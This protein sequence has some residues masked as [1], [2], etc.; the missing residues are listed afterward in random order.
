MIELKSICDYLEQFA[1]PQLA[2]DWDNVGLLVGDPQL[3]VQRI[4]TCL[5]VTPASAEEAVREGANLIVTHHPLP[6]RPLKRLTTDSTPGRLVLQLVRAGVAVYSP[7]TA[8]D[9]AAA[10]INQQ[11][12]AG[13]GLVETVPLVAKTDQ[14]PVLGAGRCGT[15]PQPATLAELAERLKAFLHIDGLHVVG[16]AEQ[17]LSRVAVA[18]G[19]A[20]EFLEQ[21][22]QADCDAL[23]VGETTFHTCLEAEAQGVA[24]L[25]PGHFASERF[26]VVKL[27]EHLAAQFRELHVWA[28]R[29][30]CDPLRW[31]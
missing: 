3:H 10:G 22:R 30:E 21:A 16:P 26:A 29:Q 2:E 8:F 19:A 15:L 31:V 18:C 1:P 23:V 4:M 28:S 27:A 13:L 14:V 6:F 12:A 7:H 24:L 9:S 20:G 5:T 11:L 17:C 25:L